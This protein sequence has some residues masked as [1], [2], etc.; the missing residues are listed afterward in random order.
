M[1]NATRSSSKKSTEDHSTD[2]TSSVVLDGPAIEIQPIHVA[3]MK[4]QEK[5]LMLKHAAEIAQLLKE[6][7]IKR[8]EEVLKARHE[9]GVEASRSRQPMLHK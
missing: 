9:G 5:I 6:A 8:A 2:S 1:S 7:D 4:A 3:L